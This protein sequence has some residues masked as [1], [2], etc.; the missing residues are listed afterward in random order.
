MDRRHA[1]RHGRGAERPHRRHA[2]AGRELERLQPRRLVGR[3][4]RRRLALPPIPRRADLER[5]RSDAGP[6]RGERELRDRLDAPR[7]RDHRRPLGR[8]QRPDADLRVLLAGAV[9]TFS[10]KVDSSAYGSCASPKTTAHLADGPHTFYVRAKDAAGN[11]DPTPASRSF[12]VADRRGPRLRLDPGGQG[13]AR[14]RGQPRDHPPLPLGPAG[15]RLPRRRL[16]TAPGVHAYGGC[17][18]SGDCAANCSA[19]GIVLIRVFSG[20]QADQVVN[21]TAAPELAER[22]RRTT[23]P[24]SAARVADTLTGGAEPTSSGG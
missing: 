23:T 9:P 20:D 18:R 13:G 3:F 19:A 16:L 6:E 2:D 8:H 12:T 21:S 5:P 7:H 17:T 4:D 10:C 1:R 14:G 22:R 15:I 24:C 11:V